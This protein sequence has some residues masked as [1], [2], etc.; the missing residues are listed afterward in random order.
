MSSKKGSPQSPQEPEPKKK[1]KRSPRNASRDAVQNARREQ[2]EI[3]TGDSPQSVRL[4]ESMRLSV[5]EMLARRWEEGLDTIPETRPELPGIYLSLVRLQ[6]ERTAKAGYKEKTDTYNGMRY[7]MDRAMAE[8]PH[9]RAL[10]LLAMGAIPKNWDAATL[11]VFQHGEPGAF[12]PEVSRHHEAP[13]F[14]VTDDGRPINDPTNLLYVV[15]PPRSKQNLQDTLH[16]VILDPQLHFPSGQDPKWPIPVA[17]PRSTVPFYPPVRQPVLYANASD[18]MKDLERLEPG[19]GEKMAAYEK[20]YNVPSF[21][22]TWAKRVAT[23]CEIAQQPIPGHSHHRPF[24]VPKHWNKAFGAGVV[25]SNIL[26]PGVHVDG[27]VLEPEHVPLFPLP[28]RDG[29][30]VKKPEYEAAR[31][32]LRKAQEAAEKAA[33]KAPA[34]QPEPPRLTPSPAPE[35]KH[36]V[37]PPPPLQDFSSLLPKRPPIQTPWGTQAEKWRSRQRS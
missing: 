12:Y 17:I 15:I 2:W 28:L 4:R 13:H 8:N 32:S 7:S 26:P 23:L 31:A 18:V 10:G 29:T 37:Q 19:I 24:Q 3:W 16:G 14:S 27:K 1:E 34:P 6:P 11:E 30:W 21:R 33:A 35:K 25:A 9:T 36:E 20:Q 5:R 22:S